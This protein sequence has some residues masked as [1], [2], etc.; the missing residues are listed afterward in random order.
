MKKK[1]GL[2]ILIF[3]LSFALMACG[4]EPEAVE[5]E[6]VPEEAPLTEELPEEDSEASLDTEDI[7]EVVATINGQDIEKELFISLLEREASMYAAQGMDLASE[8]GAELL[9]MIKQ[10][11]VDQ[12]VNREILVQAAA[13]QGI[14]ASEEEIEA[15][16]NSQLEQYQF[17]SVEQL[18]EALKA[19]NLTL[20]EFREDLAVQVKVE[21]Y[22]TEHV[23]EPEVTEEELRSTYDEMVASNPETDEAEIPTFEEYKGELETQ[24]QSQKQQEQM[25]ALIEELKANSEITIHI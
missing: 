8:D 21:K 19:E 4:D 11:V 2:G 13:D 16:L 22:M 25:M 1:I 17:E 18:E 3:G 15:E 24:L 5:D 12:L 23:D 7:P 14:K 10:G 6:T 9:D 20:E